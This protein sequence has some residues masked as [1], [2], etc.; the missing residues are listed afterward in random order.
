LAEVAQADD[1]IVS[2]RLVSLI[3][4][5]VSENKAL[6]AVFADLFSAEGAEIYLKPVEDY[7]S[8][9][10]LRSFGTVVEAA[11][12]RDETAI[13]YRIAAMGGDKANN[14]GVVINPPKSASIAF[15]EGDHIIVLAES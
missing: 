9:A 11:R 7:V 14:Y 1:F 13:G 3:L 5:Q 8:V 12:R 2:D 6:N 15:V 10:A 4:A